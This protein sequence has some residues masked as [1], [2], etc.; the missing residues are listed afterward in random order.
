MTSTGTCNRWWWWEHSSLLTLINEQQQTTVPCHQTNRIKTNKAST[1]LFVPAESCSYSKWSRCED[2]RQAS[3]WVVLQR[4][5]V[6]WSDCLFCFNGGKQHGSSTTEDKLLFV[7]VQT[8]PNLEWCVH[9]WAHLSWCTQTFQII[10]PALIWGLDNMR[11]HVLDISRCR[12]LQ[13][14]IDDE[15]HR[16]GHLLSKRWTSN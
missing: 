11:M 12:L 16:K 15:V 6:L 13:Q 1:G 8:F 7:F 9:S 4:W 10:A 14:L 5:S 2:F 3:D